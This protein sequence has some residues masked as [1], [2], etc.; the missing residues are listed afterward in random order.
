MLRGAAGSWPPRRPGSAPRAVIV[1]LRA[2][3]RVLGVLA[4]GFDG[5]AGSSDDRRSRCSRTSAR[6][7]A[8]ALDNA[9]LYAERDQR[10]PHAAALAAPARAA[11][12]SRASSSPPAT[13]RR[14]RATRSA[15]TSTTASRP[16]TG[17]W[18]LVIGDVCG[19]GAEAAALTALARYTLRAAAPAHAQP[20]RGARASST[21]RCCASSLDYRFCTVLYASL[22]PRGDGVAVV[23]G[24]RRAPAAA[25]AARRR[26]RRDGRLAGHAAGH[27]R[28]TPELAEERSSSAP[29]DALVLVH[30]RRHRG[31]PADA[32]P[33]PGGW[34]R[35]S[36]ACAGAG[37]AAIAE[38]VEREA[39]DV[40]GRRAARRRR[41]GRGA[42]AGRLAPFAAP[43]PGV[44]TAT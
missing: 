13:W 16:A 25:G 12:R 9:R 6:R 42:R 10:R 31:Q 11:G 1:P 8:L 26:R 38:A 34:P 30:R 18:A 41:G 24:D 27:R 5:L 3:G 19:K 44:A 35:S 2:R 28:P 22:T 36:P 37:A 39:L 15:A 29:G 23:R 33:A 4:A 21:R 40:A 17:D 32:R 43:G 7:A 20:A 14:A